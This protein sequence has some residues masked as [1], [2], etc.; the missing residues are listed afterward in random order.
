M[1]RLVFQKN[2]PPQASGNPRK[3]HIGHYILPL[4]ICFP[5]LVRRHPDQRRQFQAAS[6]TMSWLN[7]LL[8]FSHDKWLMI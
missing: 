5:S 2:S 4:R 8:T 6:I 3:Y 1:L 7:K